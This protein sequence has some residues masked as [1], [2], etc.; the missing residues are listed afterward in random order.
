MNC[1]AFGAMAGLTLS[2]H[3]GNF[4]LRPDLVTSNGKGEYIFVSSPLAS[5]SYFTNSNC[6]QDTNG[7]SLSRD[8]IPNVPASNSLSSA[9]D[10]KD[11]V[12]LPASVI[13]IGSGLVGLIG[14]GIRRRWQG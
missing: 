14:L 5:S 7:V 12:P 9:A 3:S 13:L 10:Y 6:P 8:I 1:L 2:F 4:E 11:R